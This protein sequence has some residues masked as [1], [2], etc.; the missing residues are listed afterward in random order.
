MSDVQPN[1]TIT[2]LTPRASVPDLSRLQRRNR[3]D[4]VDSNQQIQKP[5]A[6]GQKP[7]TRKRS[8]AERERAKAMPAPTPRSESSEGSRSAITTYLSQSVRQRARAT[9]RATN[10]LEGDTSWSDFVETAILA[11]VERRE[12]EHN[13]GE[14]YA[15]D[16]APL[17]P[18]R[19]LSR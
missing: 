3:A 2:G 13:G 6:E 4:M 18:G 7:R 19:P 12:N 15:G 8:T 14:H 10:H 9:Y 1:R 11:E 17:S 16:P 5:Q